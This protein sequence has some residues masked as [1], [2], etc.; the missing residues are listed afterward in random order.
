MIGRLQATVI[1]C[2]DPQAL[3]AFY[4]ELTGMPVTRVDPEDGW[5]VVGPVDGPHLAFQTAPDLVPPQWPDPSHP[6]QMHLDVLVDDLDAAEARVLALGA[7]RLPGGARAFRVYADPVGHP[8]C[9]V[10]GA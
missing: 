10:R 3:A 6:Q 1:D 7:T 8:F 2:P 9:L 5:T 4:S